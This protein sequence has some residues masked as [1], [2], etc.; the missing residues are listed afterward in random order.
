MPLISFTGSTKTGRHVSREV[1]GRFGRT[2]LELGGNNA[3]IVMPD[4]DLDLAFKG[5]VFAA[6]GTAGQRCTTLRRLMVHDSHFDKFA[7]R[8]VAAYKTVKIGDPLH[9]DTLMGPLHSKEQVMTYAATI[10]EA[11]KQGGKVL[12]GGRVLDTMPGNFVEPTIIE[13]DANAPV[14]QGEYFVPILFMMRFNT[15]EEAVMLNNSVPQGL[16]SSIYTRDVRNYMNW[17]GPLGS[18]CGIANCNIGNSGA[19]IGGAFGGNKET[20]GGREAGS[21][22]WKQYMRRS[23]CTANFSNDLPLA[24]GVKFDV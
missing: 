6:V 21:D 2:I 24:Q 17:I 16:S 9:P 19:E 8:M 10:E 7:K 15:F 12:T 13:I 1:A 14:L 4:A 11:K 23:T 22:S 5:S 18:D 3:S 20:G